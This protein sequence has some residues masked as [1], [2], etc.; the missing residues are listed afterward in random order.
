MAE[1]L[2]L[3]LNDARED[4]AGP[5]HVEWMSLDRASGIIR[6]RGE[7]DLASLSEIASDLIPSGDVCVML[8][9]EDVLL[10]QAAI[11]SRQMRQ[12]LQAV[13]YMVEENL[14][15][16][17]DQCH[18]SVG[19]RD[20][21]GNIPVA[22]IES[23]KLSSCLTLLREAGIAPDIM[24]I[25]VLAVPYKDG[26][27]VMVDGDRVLFRNGQS[28]GFANRTA[29]LGTVAQLLS[30]SDRADLSLMVHQSQ[31]EAMLTSR[32]LN[33]VDLK[34]FAVN[35]ILTPSTYCR[36]TSKSK[37]RRAT[38]TDHGGQSPYWLSAHSCCILQF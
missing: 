7:G 8:S 30:D 19:R 28:L 11:P 15:T 6:S 34:H 38:R 33:S 31:L 29:L 35:S 22:I 27:T 2:F 4:D 23:E 10:T 24:T 25:D 32:R 9:A 20:D 18:F 21:D 26:C 16:D 36:E 13:P 14:A 12:I 5:Y 37:L 3:R 17:I 1:N